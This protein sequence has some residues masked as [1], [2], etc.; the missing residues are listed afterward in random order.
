[1][2]KLW[3]EYVYQPRE[4][5]QKHNLSIQEL[6]EKIAQELN[7]KPVSM[8][9]ILWLC[10]CRKI[11]KNCTLLAQCWIYGRGPCMSVAQGGA[12]RWHK[13]SI[14]EDPN[15]ILVALKSERKKRKGSPP[16]MLLGPLTYLL[17]QLFYFFFFVGTL[18]NLVGTA[19]NI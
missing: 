6:Q 1:M 17:A 14:L 16:V 15:Q 9:F 13:I 2:Q 7:K 11:I 12:L 5:K 8:T 3:Y 18:N 10:M 4:S 19:N